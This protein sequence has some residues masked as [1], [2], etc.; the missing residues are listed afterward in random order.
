MFRKLLIANRGEIACR[1]ARTAKRMGIA[2]VAVYSQADRDALHVSMADEAIPIGP[3]AASSSYLSIEKLV[4]ACRRSGAEAVHPGYGF[5]SE[6]AEFARRIA[7]AGVVFIGPKPDALARMGDK[8]TSKQLA[9]SAGVS[10]IPGS[11]QSLADAEAAVR[12][13]KGIGYPV[14]LKASA[15]GGGKGMRLAFND[16]DCR[17]GFLRATQEAQASFG[18]GRVFVEKY[19]VQPRHIEIQVLAD[20]HGKVLHLGEREC[21]MQRRHQKVIEEA[22]SPLLDAATREAMG[23]QAVALAQA[24]NYQSAGTVE[25]VVDPKRNFYFLEMNTR[26]QVEHPVTEMITGIDLVEW[27]IRIAAG[28]PLSLEQAEVKFQGWAIESRVY[29][30][31]PARNFLP[32]IGRLTR[33][34]PPAETR[35]VRVDTGVCEGAEVSMHYDPMIAKLVVHGATREQAIDG[36]LESLNQFV[37][38]GPA[39]NVT[40]LASLVSHQGFRQGKLSTTLIAEEYPHGFRPQEPTGDDADLLVAVSAVIHARCRVSADPLAEDS[41]VAEAGLESCWVVVLNGQQHRVRVAVRGNEFDVWFG[42]TRNVLATHWHRGDIRFQ[43]TWNAATWNAATRNQATRN[44]RTVNLQVDMLDVGY[45]I[46]HGGVQVHAM[47]VT[48]R[49][50]ELLGCMPV[51][52]PVGNSKF[53]VSPMPGMLMQLLVALGQEVRAGQQL[54]VIEAMKMQ[55]PLHAERDGK[56]VGVLASEGETLAVDQPILKFE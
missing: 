24:V 38:R 55:N 27:M 10:T 2:T 1:I 13:A 47:V 35:S 29:A 12:A 17:E 25:F 56:I 19:I 46:T 31:D 18:D 28:E 45:R 4:D 32:S 5:L 30:E 36:M 21:S 39:N 54:A 44:A 9:K 8:L 23:R 43:A 50:A 41:A 37:V 3:A 51:K 7:D 53:V 52:N 42:D 6:Q 14:M 16:A 26:L 48:L 33:F 22:P 34:Q 11:P 49:V 20:S 40:F 15:G